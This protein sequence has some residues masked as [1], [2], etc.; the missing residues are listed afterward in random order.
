MYSKYTKLLIIF[1]MISQTKVQA[2]NPEKFISAIPELAKITHFDRTT[3]KGD[4]Q[5]WTMARDS[6]GIYYFG[7]NDG[8]ITYDG[9]KW[10]DILLPNSSAVRSLLYASNGTVYAGGYNDFGKVEKNSL[11]NYEFHSILRDLKITTEKIENVWQIHEVNGIIIFRTFKGLITVENNSS[12]YIPSESRFIHSDVVK[13]TYYIQDENLGVMSFD[14][15]LKSFN[16]IFNSKD[17]GNEVIISFLPSDKA[18]FIEIITKKGHIYLGDLTSGVLTKKHEVFSEDQNEF[19]SVA[20]KKGDTYILGT[21]GSKI[22]TFSNGKNTSQ[23]GSI[24]DQIQDNTVL[25]FYEDKDELWVLLNDGIDLIEYNA[26]FSNLFREGSV[27]DILIKNESIY[28]AT[29]NGVYFS[30]I[31]NEGSVFNFVKTKIPQGQAWSLSNIGASTIVSHD[32]GLYEI[33]DE[34]VTQISNERGFWKVIPIS[35]KNNEFLACSYNGFYLLKKE[36]TRFNITTKIKGFLESTRDVLPSDEENTFWVCHGFKGVFKVKF[37]E[38]YRRV[39]AID[40]FTD[41]NGFK[42]PFN[43]NVHNWNSDIIFSTNTG[44]YTFNKENNEFLPYPKLN[45]IIGNT[46]NT[47]KI[48]T[49]QDTTWVVLND[50]IGLFKQSDKH[51]DIDK[52]TFRNLKGD[53]NRGFEK[54]LPITNKK[55]LIGAK[56]GLYVYNLKESLDK[57]SFSTIITK[58]TKQESTKNITSQVV[59]REENELEISNST[60]VLRF[61]FATPEKT[62]TSNIKFSYKLKDLDNDWSTWSDNSF[63][64]YTHLPAGSYDFL[65]RSLDEKGI[66]G[67]EASFTF[68]VQPLWHK[69]NFAKITYVSLMI[70]IIWLGIRLINNKITE[71]RN[72]SKALLERSKKVL[73]LE[74]ERLKLKQDKNQLEE[75]VIFKSKELTNYTVQLINKK[76][77]FAEIQNDLKELKNLVKNAESKKKIIEIFKKLHQHKV[78]EEY[79]KVYDVNFEKIH[80]D[81]FKKLKYIHPKITTRELRLCAFIKMNLTN[82]EIAPLLNISVRGVETARYRVRKKLQVNQESSFN[83]FLTNL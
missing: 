37:S 3:Y 13:D 57:P 81:F 29:N 5:F 58:V 19:L 7:N 16:S 27:Y 77:A 75:D 10:Q 55:V 34:E 1:T 82:K 28:I 44:F 40:H 26:S 47:R 17:I 31:P 70:F 46:I 61:E 21:I 54:I 62:P 22:L 42:S 80:Q 69:T 35:N 56:S 60:E 45:N 2:Q 59:I 83:I 71:E 6:T 67:N 12:S 41:Q 73:N 32:L 74:I 52:N 24:Y 25:N 68:I 65:V 64:E 14:P 43:I 63:K 33:S 23:K 53:L 78:G 51:P 15:V 8:V 49:H 50:E 38:D 30:K 36:G 79:M 11:G 9:Q 66:I 76:R 4:S 39:V 72:K 18:N 48:L 20:V